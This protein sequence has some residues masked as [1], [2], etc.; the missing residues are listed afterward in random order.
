M[1]GICSI[2]EQVD[3][4]L[5]LGDFMDKANPLNLLSVP[6]PH[7]EFVWGHMYHSKGHCM[8]GDPKDLSTD[9]Q[10]PDW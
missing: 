3:G 2:K 10:G 4:A 9:P 6:G 1:D 5:A 8:K 7:V